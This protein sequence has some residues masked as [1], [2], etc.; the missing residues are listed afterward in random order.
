MARNIYRQ[1]ATFALRL[2]L[3]LAVSLAS[4]PALLTAAGCTGRAYA[5]PDTPAYFEGGGYRVEGDFLAFFLEAGG[6]DEFGLP[7]SG[8]LE[9]D[10]RTVQ[11][12]EYARLELHPENPPGYRVELSLLGDMLKRRRP[13]IPPV[14]VPPATDPHRRYYP[15]T[16]H[17][18]SHDFLAYF[19]AHGGLD[20]L[21]YPISEPFQDGGHVVQ[22]FQRAR[23]VW[24]Y[25][26]R[27][28]TREK[29]GVTWLA[30]S[31]TPRAGN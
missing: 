26:E 5:P 8:Q 17:T 21:G 11:Y 10:G 24:E 3:Y 23:L 29:I 22:D 18:I 9:E 1:P 28:V 14:G 2:I 13:P 16:G 20:R 30:W 19:D 7:I 4:F 25:G 15:A 12:F 6:E 31:S 27:G